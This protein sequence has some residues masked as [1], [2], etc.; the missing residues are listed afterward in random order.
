MSDKGSLY[1]G[2]YRHFPPDELVRELYEDGTSEL[3]SASVQR[4]R[5]VGWTDGPP[6]SSYHVIDG[7]VL[8]TDEVQERLTRE[9]E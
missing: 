8:R 9:E 4:G 1:P 7:V 6:E 3:P 5:I 2:A